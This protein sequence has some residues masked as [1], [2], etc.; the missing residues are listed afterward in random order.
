MRHRKMRYAFL[1]GILCG[2]MMAAAVAFA[3]A[4]P[5]NNDHWRV[6][7]TKRGGGAWSIDKDGNLG[8]KWLVQPASDYYG[9]S[10][11]YLV[12]HP[13]RASNSSS[14]ERL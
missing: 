4:I 3:I 9:R 7:I 2:A 11:P 8:W 14:L 13:R 1:I 10:M 5:A 12:P 6:E